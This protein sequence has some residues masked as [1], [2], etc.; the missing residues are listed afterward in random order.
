MGFFARF[1][2]VAVVGI[3]VL[4]AVLYDMSKHGFIPPPKPPL[5]PTIMGEKTGEPTK[6]E[7]KKETQ[8]PSPSPKDLSKNQ[9]LKTQTSDKPPKKETVSDPSDGA[10]GYKEGKT[11]DKETHQKSMP[12]CGKKP[13]PKVVEQ[14][15]SPST[16]VVRKGDTLAG[17]ARRY[18]GDWR[19]WTVIAW[20]NGIKRVGDLKV[21]LK[22]TIPAV[23]RYVVRAGE[24]LYS[25]CKR[26]MPKVKLTEAIKK[27]SLMNNINPDS[28]RVGQV[29]ALP[30]E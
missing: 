1:A 12:K 5:A 24:T 25:I 20:A 10:T 4:L 22:L 29:I 6:K 21:G 13:S 14:T 3:G 11:N 30:L 7:E 8:P 26:K 17:L 27:V 28:I 23:E 9:T 19:L 16:Y 15:K 18:Y 2:V